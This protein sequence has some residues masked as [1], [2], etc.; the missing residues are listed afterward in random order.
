MSYWTETAQANLLSVS[1]D[2]SDLELALKEWEHTGK[3]IDHGA[4]VEVCQLCEHRQLRYHFEIH[5]SHT[6]KTLMVGS[7][8][9]K[10]FDITV[11]DDEGNELKSED[12]VRW[13]RQ[14]IY[15]RQKEMMLDSLRE[16]WSNAEEH[17]DTIMWYVEM[18]ES[19]KGFSPASL[20][21][22]FQQMEERGIT[23]YPQIY[24]VVLRSYADKW[25]L[26]QMSFEELALI[27]PSLSE[28][29]KRRFEEEKKKSERLQKRHDTLEQ[30]FTRAPS[31]INKHWTRHV[32]SAFSKEAVG[33]ERDSIP[34]QGFEPEEAT[35]I[36]CGK[37]TRNWWYFNGATKTCK[38]RD[39]REHAI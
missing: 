3:V 29:Q 15:N 9:I 11:F 7:R 16:L 26:L 21:F 37:K 25:E 31:V 30:Q 35:C 39:C 12:K 32:V 1:Q 20:Y 23:F 2:Q 33:Q 10:K 34:A 36:I 38:C 18:F 28:Q 6:A 22:L 17:R 24:K 14:E 19:R 13:L 4:A 8:C 5:N 27:W